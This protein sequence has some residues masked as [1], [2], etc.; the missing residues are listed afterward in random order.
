MASGAKR[1][2]MIAAMIGL[3]LGTAGCRDDEQGRP[4]VKQKG[5]YEG[6]ADEALTAERL[7]DLRSRTAGQKF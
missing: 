6:S 3:S 5:V 7:L 4:M 2:L 1:A